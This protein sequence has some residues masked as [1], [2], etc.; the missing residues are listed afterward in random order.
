MNDTIANRL[1]TKTGFL[2]FFLVS[3]LSLKS[4]PG[5]SK[6]ESESKPQDKLIVVSGWDS[7]QS[8]NEVKALSMKLNS[9]GQPPTEYVASQ[10]DK[11][12]VV[13]FGE[14]HEVKETCEF[15]SQLIE[16]LHQAGVHILF[17]E[18]IP[19][20]FN[21]QIENI[22]TAKMYDE[23]AVIEIFRNRPSPTWGYQ[24]YMD[25]VKSVWQL[26]LKLPENEPRFRLIGLEDDWSEAELLKAN[27]ARRFKIVS[28]REKHMTNIVR[29]QSLQKKQ[30]AFVHIGYAHTVRHGIRVA[31]ELEESHPGRVFQVVAHHEF[32][33]TRSSG[34]I[35]KCLE[36][37]VKQSRFDSVGFDIE[38][39]P[40]S[41]LRD[42][43]SFAFK[44]MGKQ[45][46]LKDLARGYVFLNPV[47]EQTTVSWVNGF[48][49]EST[50]QDA[51]MIAKRKKWISE[52]PRTA[53]QLDQMI[54]AW[55]KKR[56]QK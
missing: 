34:A 40:F 42:E 11:Y 39:S 43:K 12:D 24:E 36:A 3:T 17:S 29:E 26:N 41:M 48:I 13:L 21:E 19:T 52:S 4:I 46:S 28:D 8:S 32:S 14:I 9:I 5:Q 45:S 44:M 7:A 20:R 56:N 27:A 31:A 51:L 1:A 25:I 10:F 54:A 47:S 37:V 2:I 53:E 50:F 35:T 30:K 38:N 22:T 15:V 18:F 6:T 33:G 23:K 16:P 49:N 55:F